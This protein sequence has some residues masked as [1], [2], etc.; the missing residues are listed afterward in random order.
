M[1]EEAE[2]TLPQ[3]YCL[4][5]PR[6]TALRTCIVYTSSFSISCFPL[7][8]MTGK[9]E[10]RVR[11]KFCMKLGKSDAETLK[12]F[13]RLLKKILEAGILFWNGTHV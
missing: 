6:N 7:A 8:A 11:I 4:S 2:V 9:I 5:L 13:V 1:R 10:Q 3:G 12:N